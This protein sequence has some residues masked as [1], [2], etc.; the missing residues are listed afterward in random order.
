MLPFGGWHMKI[1]GALWVTV[2]CLAAG[3]LP[4]AGFDCRKARTEDE[5]A[6]CANAELSKLDDEMT[7]AF[8]TASGPMSGDARRISAF[9]RDQADWVKE[10]GRCGGTVTCLK[11]EY[12][13]RIRWLRNPAHQYAGVWHARNA[14]LTFHVQKE[15][16]QL[17]VA[18]WPDRKKSAEQQDMVFMTIDG[19]FSPAR[20]NPAGEDQIIIA[21]PQFSRANAPLK[22]PCGEIR[23]SFGTAEMMGLEAGEK[24]PLLKGSEGDFRPVTPLF[25]YEPSR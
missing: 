24:C 19:K 6:I 10:R 2:L 15:G 22:A 4:A 12:A 7:A 9:R 16:G 13:S 17:Y 14:M 20:Q 3:G 18:L 21:S 25:I 8:K 5:K 1:P 11:S 23:L